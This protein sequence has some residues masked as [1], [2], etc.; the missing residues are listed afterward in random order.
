MKKSLVTS[1]ALLEIM[2]NQLETI[3]TQAKEIANLQQKLDYMI[4]QKFASSS[5]KFPSNQPSLFQDTSDTEIQEDTQDEKISYTRKKRGNKKLPPESLPHVRVEHDFKE[6][7]KVCECG[8][9]L[10]RIKETSFKQYDIIPAEF[11]VIDNIRFT[12]VCSCNCG[13]S[14]VISP[15]IPQVLSA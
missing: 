6:E 10:K 1:E 15:L 13:T 11:R 2:N 9:S 8:C 5:E 4:R 12:Y 14:P 3:D 7:D